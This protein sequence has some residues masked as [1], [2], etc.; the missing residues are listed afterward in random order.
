[1][2]DGELLEQLGHR[3]FMLT[4]TAGGRFYVECSCGYRSVTKTTE[5]IAV[6]SGVHHLRKVLREFKA[7]GVSRSGIVGARR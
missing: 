7:Q 5:K 6:G 1:M 2:D 4:K 3:G